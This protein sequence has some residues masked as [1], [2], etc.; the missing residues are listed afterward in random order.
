MFRLPDILD[1]NFALNQKPI[2]IG[3]QSAE[4]HKVIGDRFWRG[5]RRGRRGCLDE[6]CG[7]FSQ[8]GQ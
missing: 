5:A 8:G 1:I 6:F 7:S 4:Y 2:D 3:L